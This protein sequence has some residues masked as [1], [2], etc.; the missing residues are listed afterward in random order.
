[1]LTIIICVI[2]VAIN[3]AHTELVKL[4]LTNE[5]CDL[6]TPI[7]PIIPNPIFIAMRVGSSLILEALLQAGSSLT[8]ETLFFES[9]DDDELRGESLSPVKFACL[10]DEPDMLE[11]LLAHDRVHNQERYEYLL[12]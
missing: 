12:M 2:A 1:M 10:L 7:S 3:N 4:L 9:F 6:N 11:I 8:L 5:R